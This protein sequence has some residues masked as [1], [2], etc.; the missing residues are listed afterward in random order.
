[1]IYQVGWIYV[2]YLHCSHVFQYSY[3]SIGWFK[4]TQPTPLCNNID[5]CARAG[6]GLY[7]HRWWFPC[8]SIPWLCIWFCHTPNCVVYSITSCVY[9]ADS[10]STT[11]VMRDRPRQLNS[12]IPRTEPPTDEDMLSNKC[13]PF[14]SFPSLHIHPKPLSHIKTNKAEPN[15]CLPCVV[16]DCEPIS[17]SLS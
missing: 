11:G 9:M 12:H 5:L 13:A 3:C 14:F 6:F 8:V 1:M 10:G 2:H 15:H 4:T 16:F 17:L 7:K